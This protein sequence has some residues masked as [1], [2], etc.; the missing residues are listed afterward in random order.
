MPTLKRILAGFF[1]LIGLPI[2]LVGAFDLMDPEESREDKEGALAAA[3]FF[4]VPSVAIAAG[5]LISA[6]RHR[7]T[8]RQKIDLAR[9]QLFLNLLS[10]QDGE[11]TVVGFAL[12]AQI[13]IEE[14]KAYLDEKATQLGANFEVTEDGGIIY[15]FSV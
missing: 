6:Q 7:R 15:K 13:S 14:A 4:G 5:L 9:E 8:Q 1:L 11:V 10:A 2:L 3:G 12:A